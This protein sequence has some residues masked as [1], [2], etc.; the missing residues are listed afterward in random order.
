MLAVTIAFAGLAT[1]MPMRRV[2]GV[3]FVPALAL[4][5][6]LAFRQ[7]RVAAPD[8]GAVCDKSLALQKPDPGLLAP[9]TA[10]QSLAVS[11]LIAVAGLVLSAHRRAPGRADGRG[12]WIR[13]RSP[14]PPHVLR[15]RIAT[16]RNV[17]LFLL[18]LGLV[19]VW[20]LT[21]QTFAL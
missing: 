2:V 3:A 1:I 5:V 12:P 11:I 13:M 7:E 18:I 4:F 10:G 19:L 16:S 6:W 8:H 17:L 14:L 15:R 20:A 9:K 21:L